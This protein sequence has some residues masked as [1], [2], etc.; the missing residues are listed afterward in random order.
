V[1]DP[2]LSTLGLALRAGA[3]AVGEAPVAQACKTHRARLVLVAAGAA[4]NSAEK[5][6]R[7]AAE[8]GAPLAAL[9]RDKTAVGFALGRS[10]CA[11]LAVTDAG[12]AAGILSKLARENPEA[13]AAQAALLEEKARRAKKPAKPGRAKPSKHNRRWPV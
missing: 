4:D 3:L 12:F 7:L 8:C 13:F 5:A 1:N 11:V 6:R 2:V 9:P 10:V